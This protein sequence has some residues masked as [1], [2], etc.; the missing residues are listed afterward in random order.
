MANHL[1]SFPE[2]GLALVVGATGGIGSALVQALD[3]SGRFEGVLKVSRN[4]S[5]AVDIVEEASV[6]ALAGTVS[7]SGLPLRLVIDATGFL[8]DET[9]RP[10]RSWRHIEPEHLH[11]SFLVNAVGPALLM[12]H[13]LPLLPRQGKAALATLSAR[14]GSIED[15]GYGGWYAYRASKAALNQLV[16]T[17]AIELSRRWPEAIC[18]ALH[19]G[20]VDTRLTA[21]FSKQGLN[22][23]SPEEAAVDLI[24]VIDEL[25]VAQ[26]GS[27]L[28]YRGNKISW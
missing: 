1:T 2:G 9:Y 17:A 10:E 15:N 27:F 11:Y 26:N 18:T 14:V 5:P 4:S 28:D 3:V 25:T 6:R 12:K 22:V 23:R 8:H 7:D 16:R 20:T 13:L 21:P 24:K 19:P